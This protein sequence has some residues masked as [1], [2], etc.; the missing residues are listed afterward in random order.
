MLEE[1]LTDDQS[2]GSNAEELNQS[3]LI[4]WNAV[5]PHGGQFA[6]NQKA[7]LETSDQFEEFLV[8][9]GRAL[10]NRKLKITLVKKEPTAEAQKKK[11]GVNGSLEPEPTAGASTSAAILENNHYLQAKH[12]PCERITGSSKV[13]VFINPAN[14]DE[15]IPLTV[16]RFAVWG[17]A[18][19][20]M[21]LL[22]LYLADP[23]TDS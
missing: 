3:G 9:W 21:I 8:Q 6:A 1:I 22:I 18:M 23:M 17:Q 16:D 20:Y 10:E 12:M 5:N 11:Q 13:P 7:T 4:T 2:K 15:F 19:V 14:L